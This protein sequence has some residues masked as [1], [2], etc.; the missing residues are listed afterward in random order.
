MKEKNGIEISLKDIYQLLLEECRYA[1]TRNNHLLPI[2]AYDRVR[3]YLPR[4]F[5]VDKRFAISTAKQIC[6]EAISDELLIRFRDGIDDEHKNMLE[7][8]KFV[9]WLYSWLL[10]ASA[11]SYDCLPYNFK[12]YLE[13]V[14]SVSIANKEKFCDG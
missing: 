10:D 4:M 2:G 8:I 11:Y 3:E 13:W 1:Y 12:D 6:E 9:E 14:A 7:T 5:E